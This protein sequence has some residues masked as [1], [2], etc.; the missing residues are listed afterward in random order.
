MPYGIFQKNFSGKK[1]DCRCRGKEKENI[2]T[3]FW[4]QNMFSRCSHLVYCSL[5]YAQN[6]KAMCCGN[7]NGT[8]KVRVLQHV[9][10]AGQPAVTV[11]VYPAVGLT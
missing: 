9:A 5:L 7:G 3:H 6:K 10:K 8:A 1:T 4:L 2:T 11:A